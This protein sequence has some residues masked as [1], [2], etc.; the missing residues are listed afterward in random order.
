VSVILRKA[1]GG[2]Y[3]AM[4]S[5]GTG[6]DMVFAWPIAQVAVMGAESAVDIIYRREISGAEQPKQRRQQLIDEY[7]GRLMTPYIA[8]QRGYVN[9]VIMPE[10]TRMRLIDALGMLKNKP[11][12]MNT[13][14]RHGNIPL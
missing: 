1:F 2:A 3:I 10:E 7:N 14:R 9:E 8:A 13:G 11:S 6:A 12:S 5:I 4:N